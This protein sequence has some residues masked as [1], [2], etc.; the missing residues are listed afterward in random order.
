MAGQ[1]YDS[2]TNL[3][4]NWNRYYDPRVGRYITSD[5]IGLAGGL[6]TYSYVMNNPLRFTDPEGLF[7]PLLAP[8]VITVAEGIINTIGG[9]VVL[10]AAKNIVSVP[11]SSSSTDAPSSDTDTSSGSKGCP[12]ND[13]CKGL[14]DQLHK[15][16]QKLRD[17]INN[18]YDHDNLRFLGQG[19]DAKII[20]SRI[21]SLQRQIEDFRKQLAECERQHGK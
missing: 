11:Q 3:H 4:Y 6:N 19:R 15:H 8:A 12:P 13:P 20:N 18:P 17:Y 2:E 5:P 14:R 10:N 7:A 21:R 9:L 1:Y 16:E